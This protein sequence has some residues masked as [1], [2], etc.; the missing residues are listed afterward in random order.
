M[1]FTQSQKRVVRALYQLD[2]PATINEVAKWAGNMSWNT[3]KGAL[4]FLLE[5]GAVAL[6]KVGSVFMWRLKL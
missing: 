2:R 1:T 4:G 6:V 3:A 5:K